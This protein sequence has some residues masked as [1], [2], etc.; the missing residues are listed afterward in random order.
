LHE[1]LIKIGTMIRARDK[2]F[3][4]W[5]GEELSLFW[6]RKDDEGYWIQEEP[7]DHYWILCDSSWVWTI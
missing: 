4:M 7:G 5:W 1:Y 2:Y 6:Y 3:L